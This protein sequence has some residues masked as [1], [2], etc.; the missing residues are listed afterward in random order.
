LSKITDFFDEPELSYNFQTGYNGEA[1]VYKDLD[2]NSQF[3]K[4]Y[5]PN[6]SESETSFFVND[7]KNEKIYINESGVSYDILVETVERSK[8]YVEVKSTSGS[9][10]LTDK[11]PIYISPNQWNFL[12]QVNEKDIY[13][14]V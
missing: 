12:Q 2:L 7:F 14:L 5:W 8:I 3:E 10:D 11:L 6:K 4:V 13:C 1:F 9:Y